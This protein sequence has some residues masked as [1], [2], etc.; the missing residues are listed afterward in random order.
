MREYAVYDSNVK[1]DGGWIDKASDKNSYPE[2][3]NL[4]NRGR[5]ML[6]A[7]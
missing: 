3:P 1:L 2:K 5:Y 6:L 7:S 4:L